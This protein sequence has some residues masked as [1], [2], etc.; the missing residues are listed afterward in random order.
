MG[1]FGE[2]VLKVVLAFFETSLVILFLE[3]ILISDDQHKFLRK[4]LYT[5]YFLFQCF[6][7][8][9]DFPF[10]STNIYYIIFTAVIAM[11]CYLDE[12]RLKLIA[13]SM[14]VTLNYACKLMST[15]SITYFKGDILPANPFDYVLT[16]EMQALACCLVMIAIFFIIMARNNENLF[17]KIFINILIF[18]SP[19]TNLYLAVH[20]L[21]NQEYVYFEVTLLLFSYSFFLLFIIDQIVYSIQSHQRSMAMQNTF[22]LQKNHYR[23]IEEY[24]KRMARVRHDYKNHVGV[25]R[26]L[27]ADGHSDKALE[28]LDEFLGEVGKSEMLVNTGNQV[29]DALLNSKLSNCEKLGIKTDLE[30]VIPPQFKISSTDISIILSNLLDNSIEA[31]KKLDGDEKKLGIRIKMHKNALFIDVSN[32]YDG[33][34]I[35]M[36]N[37]FISTKRNSRDHGIGLGNVARIIREHKGTI[38]FSY[39]DKMFIVS[40]LLPNAY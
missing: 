37:K 11:T 6:T 24:S 23:D 38:D 30:I 33:H 15:I 25:I 1:L 39:Q 21:G 10:F 7:Y 18:F 12:A 27:I 5:V 3:H 26:S 9:I 31:L 28:Y 32:N 40:I 17:T 29:V 13:S 22:E 8:F 19:L 14:F 20:L 34:V 35:T 36:N 4:I 2:L 16:D